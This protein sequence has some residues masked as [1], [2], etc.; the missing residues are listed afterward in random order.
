MVQTYLFPNDSYSCILCIGLNG[1]II[2]NIVYMIH[3]EK[4]TDVCL[5]WSHKL[6]FNAKSL[7]VIQWEN[8]MQVI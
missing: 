7:N 6:T 3:R 4:R 1:S 2:I 8:L 5:L